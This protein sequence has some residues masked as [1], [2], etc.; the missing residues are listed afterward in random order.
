MVPISYIYSSEGERQKFTMR[1]LCIHIKTY[2]C[3]GLIADIPPALTVLVIQFLY[4][5]IDQRIMGLVDE[6]IG[7]II[8]GLG[9]FL[10][11]TS[12]LINTSYTLPC[13][14][15]CPLNGK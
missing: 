9:I 2:I 4:I 6:L 8:P 7:F 13:E 5:A 1:S 12:R 15:Y 11:L 14:V 10:F 3:R